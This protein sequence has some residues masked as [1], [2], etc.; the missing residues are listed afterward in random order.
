MAS[1]RFF[2]IHSSPIGSEV[3]YAECRRSDDGSPVNVEKCDSGL[4]PPRE[5]VHCN[6]QPCP[7]V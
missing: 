2:L 7:P 5:T 4:R 3:S 1:Y 6:Y